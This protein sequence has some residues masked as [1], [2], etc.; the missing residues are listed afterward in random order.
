MKRLGWAVLLLALALSG[1]IAAWPVE[2]EPVAWKAPPPPPLV[3]PLAP[4]D[5][6]RGVEWLGRGQL[7]GPEATAIDRLGRVHTGTADGRILRLDPVRGA[8]E[9]VAFTGGRPLGMA[10]D[11]A[12]TLYVCDAAK[13]LLAVSPG[14]ELRVL[15]TAHEGVRLGFADDV[16]VGPD[17]TVYFSDATSKFGPARSRE[18]ILEHGG[19]GRLLAWYPSTG[20]T[21]LLS[22]GSSS[23]T[24]W[25]SRATAP[26]SSSP[27][28]APTGSAATGSPGRGGEG[29]SP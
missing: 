11:A 3:G 9:P 7:S 2:I 4:N 12:G 8:F 15:A 19:H 21:E 10:F 29:P 18:D 28:P 20:K 1:Y 22:P 24:A 26:R 14:G 23:R 25:R 17:G 16:D 13:G 5:R 27:R 6:L